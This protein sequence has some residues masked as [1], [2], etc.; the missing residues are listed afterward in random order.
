MIGI[1]RVQAVRRP[2]TVLWVLF[3]L[4]TGAKALL[5]GLLWIPVTWGDSFLYLS[6]AR[7]LARLGIP[8]ADNLCAP[9]YP[10]LYSILLAPAYLLGSS[11]EASYSIALV[12]NAVISSSLLFP[13]FLLHRHFTGRSEPSL[14]VAALVGGMSVSIGYGFSVMSENLFL[15]LF[16]WLCWL[17]IRYPGL[18]YSVSALTGAV[19]GLLILTKALAWALIPGLVILACGS[20]LEAAPVWRRRAALCGLFLA[21]GCALPVVAWTW[22]EA[23]AE[24]Q[25]TIPLNGGY[26]VDDYRRALLSLVTDRSELVQYVKLG[27]SQLGYVLVS[28]FALGGAALLGVAGLTMTDRGR[29]STWLAWAAFGAG[30]WA[31]GTLHS[32]IYFPMDPERYRLFGRYVDALIPVAV[33]V[34][35]A[36]LAT[37]G[38]RRPYWIG[39]TALMALLAIYFLPNEPTIWLHRSGLFFAVHLKRWIHW[40]LLAGI[41]MGSLLVLWIGFR[42]Q[43]MRWATFALCGALALLGSAEIFMAIRNTS[44]GLYREHG[45][46]AH[47]REHFTDRDQLVLY[48]GEIDQFGCPSPI[49]WMVMY[50]TETVPVVART[51]SDL[52]EL[53]P[54]GAFYFVTRNFSVRNQEP[55]AAFRQFRMYRCRLEELEVEPFSEVDGAAQQKT[56]GRQ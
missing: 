53:P 11:P 51:L 16:A 17:A 39:L 42:W 23:A 37:A 40:Q 54:E 29:R 2:R 14:L 21:A 49:Q 30:I 43:V 45:I 28:S 34:G 18:R 13:C 46:M 47:L 25:R 36:L 33:V 52:P 50:E 24:A 41:L 10:P 38:R 20:L 19:A 1:L 26:P 9:D 7:N 32:S 8:V 3:G 56:P 22:W 12:I 44:R 35:A 5:A 48:G 27:L 55:V 6:R 4:L 15:P 31:L